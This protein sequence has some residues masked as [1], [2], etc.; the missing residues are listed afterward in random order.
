MA[1]PLQ[2]RD[3]FL[4]LPDQMEGMKPCRQRQ[5]GVVAS[6]IVPAVRVAWMTA[7]PSLLAIVPAA[8]DKTEFLSNTAG[9]AETIRPSRHLQR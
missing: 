7:V 3:P 8:R 1:A 6:M 4:G 9:T 5:F 2:S